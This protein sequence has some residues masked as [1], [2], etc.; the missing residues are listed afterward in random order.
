MHKVRATTE[1]V[2]TVELL[3]GSTGAPLET[4]YLLVDTAH[5]AHAAAAAVLV[6][7]CRTTAQT[8]PARQE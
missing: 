7:S 8:C 5:D 3:A 6:R 2:V 1:V 4:D